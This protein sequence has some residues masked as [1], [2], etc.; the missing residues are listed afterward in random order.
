[1]RFRTLA[2]LGAL[3]LAAVLCNPAPSVAPGVVSAF[4]NGPELQSI[5]PLA[6]GADGTLFAA[7]TKGAQIFA[8]DLGAKASGTTA[9]AKNVDGIDSQIASLLGTDA[10]SIVVTDMVVHPKTK[11]AYL[12]VMRGM[13]ADAK[14]ALVRVDGA[15]KL[16]LVALDGMK[17]S[18][19][20]LP[21]A[22]SANAQARRDPRRDAI[23]HMALVGNK[24]YVAGLSN[25]EFA[26]KLR[27]IPY[28]FTTADKGTSVEIF[29]GNHGQL[30][31]RSPVYAFIPYTINNEPYIIASYLCTPLVKFPVASLK[32]DS[33]VL[34][35]TIAELGNGNQPID[36]VLYKK[37][38]HEFL[39]MA[40]TSRGVMKIP[41]DGFAS[42]PSIT[43]KVTTETAG[44]KYETIQQL[45]GIVQLDLV[46]ASQSIVLA[47]TDA[48]GLNLQ[49][50]PL[51]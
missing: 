1:M 28:P 40:N 19:V 29:H 35:T 22:P 3:T 44:I 26:S 21:N 16:D 7:D 15:G 9:G 30:E 27:A 4:E 37:D 50:V 51:P 6:F 43:A 20:A 11:N 18:K 36:M 49:T 41:T 48:G 24:L 8:L 39:L 5:G 34:G 12:S 10:K 32:G 17:Y 45:K 47:K 14:P 25:E 38:G 2:G 42:L 31:T 23:T 13:G 46:D 33:K